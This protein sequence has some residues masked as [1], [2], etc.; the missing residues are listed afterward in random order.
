[1]TD[2]PDDFIDEQRRR[3]AAEKAIP[4]APQPRSLTNG[5]SGI[6][7]AQTGLR[8]EVDELRSLA[9]TTGTRQ[10]QL[11]TS[12][13]NVGQLVQPGGLTF[14]E[15]KR[16]L[17]SAAYYVGLTPAELKSWDLPDRGLRDGMKD[18]RDLKAKTN[19]APYITNTVQLVVPVLSF[20][21]IEGGFWSARKSLQGIYLASL[22]RMCAPWSVLACCAARALACVRPHVVLPDIIGGAGSLNWFGAV[23]AVSGGGKGAASATAKQLVKDFVQQRNTGSGE[24]MISAYRRPPSENEPGGLHESIMF[25]VDEIDSLTAQT[26]RSGATTMAVLRSAFSG[27]TLGFSYVNKN[28]PIMEAHSYRMTMVISVQ[29]ARAADLLADVAGGTP[30]RFMWFPGTDQRINVDIAGGWVEPLELPSPG[31][32]Q[33]PMTVQIPFAARQLIMAERVKAMQ[34][35][36]DALD[37]HAL[38]V[39]EKFAFAL[40][41]LDGRTSV[42]QEDWELSGVAAKVSDATRDWV[43]ASVEEAK[44]E[45]AVER[46]K[47]Q[48]ISSLA[49]EEEKDY[50]IDAKRVRLTARVLKYFTEAGKQGLTKRDV[51]RKL[52]TDFKWADSII[53]QL[54]SEAVL[55]T[56]EK[57]W[58]IN[59]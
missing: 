34:G 59:G 12:S 20:G 49:A 18:L 55:R 32:W 52:S 16:E 30:Q 23:T 42:S 10:T 28:T 53:N 48:G 7:Y 21:E 31:E 43:A 35:K 39:R 3:E 25:M 29:P 6:G 44:D 54:T 4:P 22:A 24:G 47:M 56:D 9:G 11:N 37:G 51:Q 15:A 17:T 19:G 57:R 40:A 1:M 50:R 46:G 26:K 45:E 38:F 14:E 8:N 58:Y 27:E 41:V 13:Y 2:E 33:Y 5:S 36:T